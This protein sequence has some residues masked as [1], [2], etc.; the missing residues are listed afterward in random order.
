M[1]LIKK[2]KKSPDVFWQEYEE[3]TGEKVLTH[4]LG[5][6]I[7]GWDEFDE[8]KWNNLWGLIITTSGGFRFH[9]FPQNSWI[10]VL[11]RNAEKAP[12]KEKTFFLPKEK[13]ISSELIKETK[14]WKKIFSSDPP[15]YIITF[16]DDTGCEK[17]LLFEAGYGMQSGAGN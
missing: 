7:S 1:A 8:K 5:R 2:E 4:G 15:L 6:Y 17:K 16:T 10:D 11:T 13:I 12:P 3:N 14:W 9:H